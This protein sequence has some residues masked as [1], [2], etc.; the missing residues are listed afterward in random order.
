MVILLGGDV[1]ALS[2]I[3]NMASTRENLAL[4]LHNFERENSK[5][6]ESLVISSGEE[7][8]GT[9]EEVLGRL[10]NLEWFK[11]A[12][13]NTTTLNKSKGVLNASGP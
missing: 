2:E 12:N 11:Y 13:C 4:A 9:D 3:F 1:T 8:E 10:Q 7:S 5:D 6:D